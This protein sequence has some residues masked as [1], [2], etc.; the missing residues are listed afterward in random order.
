[1]KTEH[2]I[3]RTMTELRT[4]RGWTQAD[5]AWRMSTLGVRW[6]PNRVTQLETFRRPISLFETIALA[7]AFE[8]PITEL[9]PGDGTVEAPDGTLV[10]L[11]NVRAALAGDASR[12]EAGRR[13]AY[14]EEIRKLVK[15]IGV[16][17]DTFERAAR[18]VFGR[19]F[20]EER[21]ARLGDTS[22][23]SK[24]SA[25]TKRGHVTRALVDEIQAHLRGRQHA[26]V[27]SRL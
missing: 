8:V 1:M 9:L 14:R 27:C 11:A 13:L 3:A 17:Q 4:S 25:R 16:D 26:A 20:L 24:G 21:E 10:P 23:L 2:V 6:T 5:L 12:Q 7:W 22:A 19:S 15:R 18:E